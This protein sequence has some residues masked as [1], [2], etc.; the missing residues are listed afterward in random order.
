MSRY[1][2]RI[3]VGRGA[4]IWVREWAD[5]NGITNYSSK[6][7]SEEVRFGSETGWFGS[8]ITWLEVKGVVSLLLVKTYIFTLSNNVQGEI[9]SCKEDRFVVVSRLKEGDL[10]IWE[11]QGIVFGENGGNWG[12]NNDG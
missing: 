10:K 3:S 2:A 9:D 8:Y 7:P 11:S 12:E 5:E 6:I 4:W 1:N